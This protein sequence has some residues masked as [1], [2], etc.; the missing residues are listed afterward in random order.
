[1]KVV[2]AIAEVL[3][4]LGSLIGGFLLLMGGFSWL[5]VPFTA[6]GSE[7]PV[8]SVPIGGLAIG[9]GIGLWVFQITWSGF[10]E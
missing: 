7:V 8:W 5:I 4:G 1:M 2:K 3:I 9:V 10:P 6:D